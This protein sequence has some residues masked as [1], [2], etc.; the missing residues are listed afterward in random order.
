M[1]QIRSDVIKQ[2]YERAP[3]R[4]LLYATGISKRQLSQ[5]F[6]GLA[7]GFTDL[8]PGHIG[9][10][11]L[12]RF[13]EKGIHSGGGVSFIFGIPGICDGIAMGHKGMHYS[14]SSREL[15]A[16]MVESITLAHALDGLVLLTDCDKIT[17]GMLM[18]AAR[19][20]IPSIVV[21]AGPMMSGMYR[22][23]R[24]SLVRDTF[25]AVGAYSAGKIDNAELEALEMCA[26][27][28][29]GSCQGVYTANTMS[30]ITE[31]MGM[32][33]PGCATVLAGMAEKRRIAY[34]SGFRVVELVNEDITSRKIMTM[35]AM[36]NAIRVN[37]AIGGSTNT[38][39]HLPAIAHEAGIELPL[40]LFDEISRDTP[41]I[42]DIRPG[43]EHFMEDVDYAG[44]IPAVMNV[45]E[46][47]LNDVPTVSGLTIK[48]IAASGVVADPDVIR[49][50]DRAYHK[51][52]GVAILR[53]SLAPDGAV[54]KQTAVKKD[55]MTFAGEAKVFDGEEIAMKAILSDQVKAGN[56]IVIRYEGPK[57]GPGMREMLL[58]TAAIVGKGL[59]DS[60]A[61]ITDG[62]FSG[63]TRGP[64]LG[65][66]SPE[67]MEGGPIAVVE[68]G[69][70][71]V[72]DIPN[73]RLDLQIPE[74][75]M[76]ERLS[77]W[78]PPEPKIKTGYLARY[79]KLVTSANTGA[80][81]DAGC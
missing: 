11:E 81:L 49:S 48:E 69:D 51:E 39:L 9:M 5:P 8:V 12:E 1:F 21:T 73:R 26:C 30:C 61:L 38:V 74:S 3:H 15:I 28:G 65:H 14:L 43:G 80:V 45:L 46:S 32:S 76:K 13:I 78:S 59:A 19:L 29:P 54:V 42:T 27:P 79:S 4:A 35:A 77:K 22:M 17:P 53:G 60:V 75:E 72:I 31:A 7:S 25:E 18:A 20:D 50:I 41:H 23:Q 47:K 62:R 64:C 68:D 58:P 2:G 10:R 44:G 67:A 40:D 33:L 24:R 63:G 55:M 56:V 34:A 66:V 57:G 16:D 6:I 70:K 71:I 52:G 37:M 36:E